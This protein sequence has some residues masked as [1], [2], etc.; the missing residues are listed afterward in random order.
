GRQQRPGL[1]HLH[2]FLFENDLAAVIGYLRR[3]PVPFDLVEGADFGIAEHPLNL[4]RFPLASGGVCAAVAGFLTRTAGALDRVVHRDRITSV[5]H[6]KFGCLMGYFRLVWFNYST[7]GR[8][9]GARSMPTDR[10]VCVERLVRLLV[11]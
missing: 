2:L 5:D 9:A 6:R 4:Q 11:G 3:P 7:G 10:A 8:T 1:G